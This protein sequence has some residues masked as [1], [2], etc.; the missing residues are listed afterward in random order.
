M[1][2]VIS[3]IY[4]YPIKSCKALELTESELSKCKPTPSFARL[5]HTYSAV[6]IL[7]ILALRTYSL[8]LIHSTNTF[9]FLS[10]HT[11]DLS[12]P[13]IDMLVPPLSSVMQMDFW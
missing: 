5:S 11:L 3:K 9:F 13:P 6:L 7:N 2:P 10:D 12:I 4:I 8:L 1:A